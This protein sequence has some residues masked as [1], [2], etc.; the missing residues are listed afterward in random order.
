M[1]I[2]YKRIK[3]LKPHCGDCGE[4]LQGNNSI[5]FP[6]RCRCGVWMPSNKDVFI[7]DLVAV[8]KNRD[9]KTK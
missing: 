2:V 8:K 3:I 4:L 9:L 7:F 1:K 5:A 6:Y